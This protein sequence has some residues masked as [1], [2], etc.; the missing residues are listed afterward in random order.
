MWNSSTKTK[1]ER[2]IL[3][4]QT[5]RHRYRDL[6]CHAITWIIF[7]FVLATTVQADLWLIGVFEPCFLFL[8][9]FLFLLLL[10]FLFSLSLSLSD[11]QDCPWCLQTLATRLQDDSRE[12]QTSQKAFPLQKSNPNQHHNRNSILVYVPQS[13]RKL[14][15]NPRCSEN[16]IFQALLQ[17]D[18][19]MV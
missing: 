4:Y 13:F 11:A 8:F 19:Y 6:E 7:V 9:L 18:V 12:S 1:P 2:Q 15:W 10:L 14:N 17:G 5:K 16:N 3:W